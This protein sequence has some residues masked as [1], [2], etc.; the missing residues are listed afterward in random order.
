MKYLLLIVFAIIITLSTAVLPEEYQELQRSITQQSME[1]KNSAEHKAIKESRQSRNYNVGDTETF[2]RWNLSVMPPSWVQTPATCRG[3][4]EHCYVFVANSEWTSHMNQADVDSVLANFE[5]HTM[6]SSTQGIYDLDTEFFG[7]LPD[8]LDNDPKMIIFYS[9]LGS[10][11]GT[12]FDGYF[13]AY[14]QVTEA[15][16]QQMNPS[17]HS[18]ECEMIYMTCYPLDPIE[19]IRLSVLA[20]EMQHLI[21]WGMDINED[22][23]VNEGCSEYA[24]YLYGLPDPITSFPNNPDN[25]LT[26][27]DQQWS[28]YVQTYLFMV[29]LAENFSGNAIISQIVTESANGITGI[30]NALMAQGYTIPFSSVFT[31]WTNA[32]FLND[33]DTITLPNFTVAGTYNSY[34]VNGNGNVQGWAAD[35]F[36][37][38][39][40]DTDLSFQFNA[41]SGT[42][43]VNILK[44]NVGGTFEIVPLVADGTSGQVTVPAFGN[45]FDYLIIN[46]TNITNT[47]TSYTF[48]VEESFN[49]ERD[50]WVYNFNNNTNTQLAATT[51][52]WG[53]NCN[54]YVANTLWQT[55]IQ[56]SDV[57]LIVRV[58]EDSTATDHNH[59]IF[60]MDTQTF[61]MPSDIDSNGKINILIYDID[62]ANING[63]F[64]PTDLSGGTHSNNMELINLDKNPH[65]SGLNSSYCFSTIAH[66]FQHLIQYNYDTNESTWVNE[67]LSGLAQAVNGWMSPYWMVMFTNN[68]D[69]NLTQ[70]SAGADYP[71]AYLFMQYLHEHYNN[72]NQGIIHNLV[73]EPLNSMEG[74]SA[75]LNTTGWTDVN[76]EDVFLNWV[77]A[78]YVNNPNF[79]DG[80]YSYATTPIGSGDFAMANAATHSSYPAS[81]SLTM[82]HWSV[83][84][85]TFDNLENSLKLSFI[86]N[87]TNSDYKVRIVT[88]LNSEPVGAYE[89]PLDATAYGEFSLANDVY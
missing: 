5:D 54:V 13:S 26:S 1:F 6:A 48:H 10:F 34:P 25:N 29:Y 20:H 77:T 85:L 44:V 18:N 23:W 79:A 2:W 59:G 31:G 17:G 30:Q 22:T 82:Q 19:P 67:G 15:Q 88:Y 64:S 3:V 46:V 70:W 74:V 38:N 58:F 57:D 51:R 49:D 12:S 21:H 78:N 37:F 69:N 28:D 11:N 75:A 66:E 50:F 68:P 71:Q 61:G 7:P 43:N 84:Y 24:M 56:Q 32:N 33:Y 60:Y 9:A 81:G 87:S 35:Y 53:D 36:K 63:Y 39:G 55:E 40:G 27:W 83:N 52:G 16:A 80:L 86:G 45:D 8:E 4:G 76:A 65:G 89:M 14:N 42:F 47:Q 41:S 73:V 62:D 72:G